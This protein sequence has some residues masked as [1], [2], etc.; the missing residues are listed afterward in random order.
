MFS[1][2]LKKGVL[3]LI[4]KRT[5]EG[6]AKLRGKKYA[7]MSC[8]CCDIHNFK[9]KILLSAIADEVLEELSNMS[10]KDSIESLE[11]CSSTISYAINH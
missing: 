9:D 2:E 4:I 1:E 7:M 8:G 11:N 6:N 5:S 10:D 3:A